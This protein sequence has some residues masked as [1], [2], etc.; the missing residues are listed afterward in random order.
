MR[1]GRVALRDGISKMGLS[2]VRRAPAGVGHSVMLKNVGIN[3]EGG[4]GEGWA[5]RSKRWDIEDGP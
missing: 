3:R 1:D 2:G 4:A 5:C